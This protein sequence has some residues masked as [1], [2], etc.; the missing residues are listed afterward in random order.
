MPEDDTTERWAPVPGYE[1][2]YEVSD[3][4]RVRSLDRVVPGGRW[5]SHRRRGVLMA[6]RPDQKGY[7]QVLLRR[8]GTDRCRKVHLLVLEAFVG[9]CPEGMEACH[10]N[11][12]HGDA[13]LA[14]L[15]WDTRSGNAK[16]RLRNGLNAYFEERQSR[17]RCPRGHELCDA[18]VRPSMRAKGHRNCWACERAYDDA[19]TR[20][21]RGEHVTDMYATAD[22][23]F[24]RLL[25]LH[26]DT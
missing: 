24:A 21:N 26:A 19:R 16:D 17:L 15:R 23:H 20:K 25:G 10:A 9:P 22:A 4:G 11:D 5:G 3:Q 18:N 2:Y 7:P 12:E 6:C 13:R 14:N 8:S 1:G